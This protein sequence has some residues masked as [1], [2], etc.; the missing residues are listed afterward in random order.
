MSSCALVTSTVPFE[1]WIEAVRSPLEQWLVLGASL[2]LCLG[3]GVGCS[4]SPIGTCPSRSDGLLVDECTRLEE[5][6]DAVA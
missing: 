5:L 1:Q 2:A 4:S 6:V 3:H